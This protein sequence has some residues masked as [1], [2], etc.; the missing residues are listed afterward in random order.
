MNPLQRALIGNEL[1]TFG[2]YRTGLRML[3][4]RGHLVDGNFS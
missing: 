3:A 4:A 1:K 2:E